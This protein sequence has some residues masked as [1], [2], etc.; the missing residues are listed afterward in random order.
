MA[1]RFINLM[2][3]AVRIWTGGKPAQG[4]TPKETVFPPSGESIRIKFNEQM[5]TSAEL[6]ELKV[7][8][9]VSMTGVPDAVAIGIRYIV[10]ESVFRWVEDRKDFVYP[11]DPIRQGGKL[12]AHRL[13]G[14]H[15]R[16]QVEKFYAGRG[17]YT[18]GI[19]LNQAAKCRRCGSWYDEKPIRVALVDGI[20]VVADD[21]ATAPC[22][23]CSLKEVKT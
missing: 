20:P 21:P 5:V 13:L 12:V 10:S 1:I 18:A 17:L 7:V 19:A 3:Y 6:V 11:F 15:T 2:P 8:E 4:R 9:P 16:T 14:C 22:P 23:R